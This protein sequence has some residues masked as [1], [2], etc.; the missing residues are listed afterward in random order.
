MSGLEVRLEDVRF[1]YEDMEMHFDFSIPAG[2]LCAVMGPSGAGKTT[3]LNLIA[4]FETPRGGRVMIG[5]ADMTAAPPAE[6]P[7]SMIFQEHNLFA[8]LDVRTNVALGIDPSGRVSAGDEA[9]IGEA[10][11][12]TGLGGLEGR[13]PGELSGG[14]RQRVAIARAL[15]RER[16]V[17]L[18]DEPFAAL[19][20]SLREEMLELVAEI[21]AE[22]GFTILLVTHQP[23]DARAISERTLFVENGRVLANAPTGELFAMAAELPELAAYLG[24][25]WRADH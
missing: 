11:E 20:P 5:G 4:G 19:G 7:V 21:H 8:H 12:R 16:P 23:G 17:M 14:Q 15:L 1:R 3:V 22:K 6:R 24:A 18:L 9:R 10:L 25:E 2:E 13:L